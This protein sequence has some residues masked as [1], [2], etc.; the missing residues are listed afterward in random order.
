MEIRLNNIL[1]TANKKDLETSKEKIKN[2]DSEI[3]NLDQ[4]R[5]A[6]I[7]MDFDIKAASDSGIVLTTK[8]ENLL[9]DL[10][11]EILDIDSIISG[12]M[13]KSMK[14]CVLLDDFWNEKREIYVKKIKNKEKIEKIDEKDIIEKIKKNS[15]KE[16]SSEFED[17]LEIGG[18]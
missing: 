18:E 4:L 10:Y 3:D 7:L 13:N 14:I 5:Y 8:T 9:N 6:N 11:D 2:L 16:K 15:K 17:L 1:A 12:V